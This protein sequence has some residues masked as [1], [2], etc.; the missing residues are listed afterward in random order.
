MTESRLLAL[1]KDEQARY[2]MQALKQPSK[3]NEFE[4]GHRVGVMAGLEQA[5]N[6]LLKAVEDE[7]SK[8][9]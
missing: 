2:A 3:C 6:V 7:N 5:I 9:L 1:L 8:D 4:Y